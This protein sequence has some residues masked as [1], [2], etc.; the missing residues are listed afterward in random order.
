MVRS[1]DEI[2]LRLIF[3]LLCIL[4]DV[5]LAFYLPFHLVAY[6]SDS[7]SFSSRSRTTLG[8]LPVSFFPGFDIVLVF[9]QE[10]GFVP[11][12]RGAQQYN[13]SL[14]LFSLSSSLPWRINCKHSIC[15]HQ[16]S[17]P[18]DGFGRDFLAKMAW[19]R[20]RF[21]SFFFGRRNVDVL[22]GTVFY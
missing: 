15:F 21:G 19:H 20:T 17:F 6:P 4:L 2:L 11:F 13:P 10:I 8:C 5:P 16:D 22:L 3:S 18:L 9:S 7:F 12:V 1:A 14:S